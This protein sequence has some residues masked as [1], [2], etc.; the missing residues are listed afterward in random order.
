MV[1]ARGDETQ[2]E[3]A[4]VTVALDTALPNVT[5]TAP[6]LVETPVAENVA[7]PREEVTAEA[8]MLPM[9]DVPADA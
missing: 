1:A 4:A 6:N 7:T 9:I 5:G 3:L 8:S 2:N